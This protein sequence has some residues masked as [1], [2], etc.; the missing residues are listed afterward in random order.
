MNVYDRAVEIGHLVLEI[1]L[2]TYLLLK[3]VAAFLGFVGAFWAPALKAAA[4]C[5][6]A[7]Q[8][9]HEFGAWLGSR[10]P[11]STAAKAMRAARKAGPALAF[12]VI[13]PV[14]VVL[15]TAAS[16]CAWFGAHPAVAPDLAKTLACAETELAKDAAAGETDVQIGIDLGVTCGPDVAQVVADALANTADAGA[17]SKAAVLRAA[18][19]AR[20]ARQ[21]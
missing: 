6:T 12:L 17:L 15:G 11:A 1:V 18:R 8:R 10:L 21:K 4:W 3:A 14:L 19:A 9:V 5:A 20:A 7:D 16:G 2:A 13:G